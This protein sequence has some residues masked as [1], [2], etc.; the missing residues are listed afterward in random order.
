M[1]VYWGK[2]KLKIACGHAFGFVNK[3]GKSKQREV[4]IKKEGKANQH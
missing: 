4:K 2:K 1:R 3:R